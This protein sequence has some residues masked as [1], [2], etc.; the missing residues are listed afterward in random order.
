MDGRYT[1]FPY[2]FLSKDLFSMISG[3]EWLD[4]SNLLM[5]Y[6]HAGSL[7]SQGD[8]ERQIS[9][10]CCFRMFELIARLPKKSFN[11]H[12][13]NNYHQLPLIRL[14]KRCVS[15]NHLLFQP[16]SRCCFCGLSREQ[17][18]GTMEADHQRQQLEIEDKISRATP[19]GN[20][21]WQIPPGQ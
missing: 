8:L 7:V 5:C 2:D 1:V 3:K 4:G 16:F 14:P 21:R 12:V 18:L 20:Q 10:I 13:Q 17:E 11:F 15:C 6:S 19:N 9:H